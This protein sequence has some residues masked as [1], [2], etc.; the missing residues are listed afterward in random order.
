VESVIHVKPEE[1]VEIRLP[2]LVD[3]AG[4]FAKREFSIRIRAHQLR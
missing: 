2:K 3:S 4:P 1:T